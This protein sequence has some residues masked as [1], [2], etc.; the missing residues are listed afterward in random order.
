MNNV[1]NPLQHIKTMAKQIIFNQK[2]DTSLNHESSDEIDF[3]VNV[4]DNE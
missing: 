4:L 1:K 2:S 3:G